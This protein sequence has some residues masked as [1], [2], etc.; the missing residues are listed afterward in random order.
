MPQIRMFL[1]DP[2]FVNVTGPITALLSDS[3][4]ARLRTLTSDDNI[5]PSSEYGGS[6]RVDEGSQLPADQGT[7]HI[8]IVD[9]YESELV[10]MQENTLRR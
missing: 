2:A 10:C 1:G 6:Y 4:L 3:Y 5:L 7:S 9:R 8:S